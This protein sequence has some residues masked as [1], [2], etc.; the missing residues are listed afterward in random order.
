MK[1]TLAILLAASTA[2]MIIFFCGCSDISDTELESCCHSINELIRDIDFSRGEINGNIV[3]LY[4]DKNEKI[5]EITI[6]QDN[7]E[8]G[9]LI[10]YIRKEGNIIYFIRSVAVDDEY[11]IMFINDE[12][13]NLLNGIK[14][15]E[16][17]GGNSYSYSSRY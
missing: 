6:G 13:N 2:L 1:K 15:A 4:S 7:I 14:K 9:K 17:I 5:N 10:K 11:G 8:V 3:T 12:S 16:R